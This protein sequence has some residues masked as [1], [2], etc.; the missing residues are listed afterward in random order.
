MRRPYRSLRHRLSR[1][2]TAVGRGLEP[3][4]RRRLHRVS[5]QVAT[6]RRRSIDGTPEPVQQFDFWATISAIAE[7]ATV[8]L[9]RA[10]IEV[11]RLDNDGR[12][13]LAIPAEARS[14]A[15]AAL[16]ADPTI[17]QWWITGPRKR[18][19]KVSEFR[20]SRS[21]DATRLTLFRLLAAPNGE[22]ITDA[23]CGVSLQFW[24]LAEAGTERPDG[25]LHSPGTRLAPARN[26]LAG[27]L[28]ADLWQ[29]AQD[30][31][32]RRLRP[33]SPP[34]LLHITEPI[35]IVYTWVDDR[36]PA[37]RQRRASVE[38]TPNGLSTDALHGGRTES[39]D[40][41]RYS[42]RSLCSYAG[43]YRRIWLVT[44]D[45]RP[46]WLANDPRL[47]MV[48]H[49]DIFSDPSVL[50]TFNSHAIESQLHHIDGLA[51][52]FLYLNDDVF[53]GRPIRPET[54]FTGTGLAKFTLAP[55]AIDRQDKPGRLNGAMLAARNNRALLSAD[56]GR[57][58]TNR[59]QH[60]PHAHRR[61][62][63]AGFEA[64]HP[65][66]VAQ[67]AASRF[68][69]ADDLSL[70]SELGHYWAYA[71]GQAVTTTM[72]FRYVD[73]GSPLADEYLDSLLARRNF[74]CFCINDA[75]PYQQPVDGARV[76]D[77]L[78]EYFPV[79]SP[80]ERTAP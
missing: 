80:F 69:S 31:P 47:T 5:D 12:S 55:V 32:K 68:R 46:S 49:R 63:L 40:E 79:P 48:S 77:F 35:D 45:Q 70:S 21:V 34:H 9:T 26:P 58:V 60:I 57:T 18:T 38:P 15:L 16:A 20:R 22:P 33:A 4:P 6:L 71:H 10:G 44:D 59:V 1:R 67:V 39:R 72:S 76:T 75:G 51:E 56:L 66:R 17:A 27:Y 24:E 23:R 8:A 29:Q 3:I 42:L 65:D 36:D 41:L 53:I 30:D 37:W 64:R 13:I 19:F 73:I 50:P 43:W 25:G 2:F 62:S 61:S 7:A 74:D 28:T 11:V 14:S 52:H 54:F 78:A